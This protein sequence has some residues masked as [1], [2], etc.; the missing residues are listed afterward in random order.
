MSVRPTPRSGEALASSGV[1]AHIQEA[2]F[3]SFLS[4][5]SR[6]DRSELLASSWEAAVG[7][8]EEIQRE[9]F[10]PGPPHLILV[11]SGVVRI[12]RTSGAG[13]RVTLRLARAGDVVGT[14]SVVANSAPA[15]VQAV[16]R[17]RV[18]HLSV[19]TF[20]YVAKRNSALSWAMSTEISR[21]LFAIQ[22]RMVHNVFAS[23]GARVARHLL[24]VAEPAGEKL[25]VSATQQ[26]I[27]DAIGSVREVVGRTIASFRD[28][29]LVNRSGNCIVVLDP[30]RLG[31][32]VSDEFAELWGD[33]SYDELVARSHE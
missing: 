9:L 28:Q 23:V 8:G 5:A 12:Y 15:G 31:D 22:E 1:P 7:P 13:R 11:I 2:W 3:R 33:P 30:V 32:V 14:P 20:R 10:R 18:L 17:G 6:E 25:V 29:G 21:S 19:E 4:E 24:D 27:A 16:S 26:D